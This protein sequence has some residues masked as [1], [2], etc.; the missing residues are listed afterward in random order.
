MDW[1]AYLGWA[2][3]GPVSTSAQ[4]P[5]PV[6][7]LPS[8]VRVPS[9]LAWLDKGARKMESNTGYFMIKL[10]YSGPTPRM[11]S[12]LKGKGEKGLDL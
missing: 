6:H 10:M 9:L 8:A 12:G 4:E 2:L 1:A 11:L 5:R 7:R 3:Y